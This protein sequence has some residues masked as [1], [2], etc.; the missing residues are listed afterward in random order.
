MDRELLGELYDM[1][2]S[3]A[4]FG[5]GY[6]GSNL[7]RDLWLALHTGREGIGDVMMPLRFRSTLLRLSQRLGEYPVERQ[8]FGGRPRGHV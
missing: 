5:F 4:E 2:H 6:W 8:D 1:V 3:V 7:G